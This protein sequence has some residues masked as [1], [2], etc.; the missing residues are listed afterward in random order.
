MKLKLIFIAASFFALMSVGLP[1][2]ASIKIMFPPQDVWVS[3]DKTTGTEIVEVVGVVAKEKAKFVTVK[4]KRGKLL[5]RDKIP[6]KN[7]AFS[8]H[9]QLTKGENRVIIKSGK[10][11]VERKIFLAVSKGKIPKGFKHYYVHPSTDKSMERPSCDTCHQLKGRTPSYKRIIPTKA[12][13]TTGKCHDKIGKAKYIHG[14]IGAKICVFCH[15]PHGSVLPKVVSRGGAD[16]CIS[17]HQEEKRIYKDKVIMP[18]VKEGNCIVCHDPH[19][20]SQKFQLIGK[21]LEGLCFNCHDKGIKKYTSLHGPM[22]QGECIACHRPHSS[23]YKGLLAEK[24]EKFCFLCHKE[25]LEQFKRKFSHKPQTENCNSCHTA[26]GSNVTFQLKDKEPELCYSCHQKTH[27]EVIKEIKRAK[28]QHRGVTEGKCS[29]CHTVHSTNFQK[30]LKAPLKEIC[31]VCHK[32]LKDKVTSSKYQHGAVKEGNCNACHTSHGAQYAHLLKKY[33]PAE[34]YAAYTPSEYAMCF[35]CHN[36]DICKDETTKELTNFR[37]G[38]VNLHFT[39][40]NRT[41]GRNC[42]ACHEVHAGNQAKHI[43]AEVPFGMWSYPIQFTPKDNGGSCVVGCHKPRS[44]DRVKAAR[45]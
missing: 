2:E 21:S 6:I 3:A 8:L 30:Q 42:K 17:C 23:P 26:H 40:V 32:E 20:S 33:F 16:L 24:N 9:V 29:A 13:C 44:Y 12:N 10:S 38:S 27:P 25:R 28:V 34:F 41:K 5:G 11:T 22:K 4:V 19:Q 1:V 15:N 7:G 43:R 45:N 39:H 18:P 37:N 35:E 31:F 14:P 36:K